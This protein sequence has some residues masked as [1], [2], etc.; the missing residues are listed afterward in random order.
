MA[1]WREA[2]L[3]G[4]TV[5]SWDSWDGS[6]NSRYEI[7]ITLDKKPSPPFS[8]CLLI[9][10]A[11]E[12]IGMTH[13]QTKKAKMHSSVLFPPEKYLHKEAKKETRNIP[14]LLD[15][16]ATP[17]QNYQVHVLPWPWNSWLPQNPHPHPQWLFLHLYAKKQEIQIL[18]GSGGWPTRTGDLG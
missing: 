14:E 12:S 7:N 9:G 6:L 10:E 15:A 18:L 3:P 2:P 1:A 17:F 11:T 16:L 4:A 8:L 13:I 5:Q